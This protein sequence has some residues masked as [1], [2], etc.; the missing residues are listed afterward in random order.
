MDVV[1]DYLEHNE[2]KEEE[3]RKNN[4]DPCQNVQKEVSCHDQD[5][6]AGFIFGNPERF[7]PFSS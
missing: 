5:D 4:P 6:S 2:E 7:A 1:P 3:A